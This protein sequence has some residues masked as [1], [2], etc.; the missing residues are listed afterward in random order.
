M[1]TGAAGFIGSHTVEQLLAA[2]HHVVGVDDLSTGSRENLQSIIASDRFRFAPIDVLDEDA[3]GS[4]LSDVQPAAIIHL[5]ALV[6]VPESI[7]D[8]DRNFRLNLL[9]TER[10]AAGARRAR[11]NRVVFASSAA[12]YGLDSRMPV[13]EDVQCVPRSPYAAAKLASENLL[14]GYSRTYGFTVRCQRFFNVYGPRQGQ[15]SP[16]S[17]V[18]SLFA[19]ACLEGRG[20]KIHGDGEQTREFI[21]VGDVARANVLAATLPDVGSGVANICTGRSTSLNSL[22]ACLEQLTGKR[23]SR[24]YGP[25]RQG[26]IRDSIGS[27]EK[28]SQALGFVSQIDLESGLGCYI[29][30]LQ[31]ASRR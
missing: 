23:V 16:Y 21:A 8:P 7:S 17:G 9:A 2:G 14:L 29:A 22:V 26:D 25:E 11:V 24:Q 1:V 19:S 18:I 28:A 30:S 5:A 15:N 3:L 4:L 12:T 20:V 6:S 31:G 13:R 10:I 27:P